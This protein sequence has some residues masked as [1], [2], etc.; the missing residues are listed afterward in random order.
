MSITIQIQTP[1]NNLKIETYYKFINK[2]LVIVKKQ[3]FNN[4]CKEGCKNY[5]KKYCCPPLTPDFQELTKNNQGLFV[6]LFICDLNQI[7]STEY[8]KV[9]IANVVMKSRIIKLMRFLEEE[10]NTIF[11]STG[12]CNLCKP[13]QLKLNKPCKHPKKRRYCLESVG[14][15]CN[16]ISKKL[17]NIP[18]LWYKNKKA[19]EY[20]LVICGLVCNKEN[21]GKIKKQTEQWLLNMNKPQ[22]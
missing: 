9:R 18:I 11:L 6:V 15:D 16:H 10:F 17:F 19:P 12:S 5:N 7:T 4:M 21:L 20:T 3:L 22:T 14:V 13:C 8:N 1:K 2:D